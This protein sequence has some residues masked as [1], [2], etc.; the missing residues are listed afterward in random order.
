MLILETVWS[1]YWE[2]H[3]IPLKIHSENGCVSVTYYYTHTTPKLSSLKQKPFLFLWFVGWKFMW[4]IYLEVLPML[5]YVAAIVL[6]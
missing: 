6:F 2:E 5:T 4:E 1:I 3:N